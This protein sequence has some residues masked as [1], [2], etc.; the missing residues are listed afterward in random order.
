MG[1]C[2]SPGGRKGLTTRPGGKLLATTL[3]LVVMMLPAQANA[4][5][6]AIGAYIPGASTN[7]GKIDAYARVVG[8][9]P[10]IVNMFKSWPIAPFYGPQ[11]SA[12]A[13]RGAVPLVTWQPAASGARDAADAYPLPQIAAGYYDDYL[14][15]SA[16][17][18]AEW[19]G[20]I[21]V[22]FAPEMN[23]DF[24]P[25]G[26]GANGNTPSDFIGAWRRV[27]TVFR[28]AGADNVEWV[29]APNNGPLGHFRSLYPGDQWVDWLGLSAFNHGGSWGWESFTTTVRAAYR[30]LVR[31]SAKPIILAEAGSGEVGGSKADWITQA[32]DRQLP[33]FR[34]IRALVWFD[35]ADRGADYR[36][37]SSRAS[38]RAFRRATRSRRYRTT[39]AQFLGIPSLLR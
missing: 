13:R 17:A 5:R 33:R 30:D 36:V 21:L 38:S 35:D 22:R 37:N 9:R 15:A 6:V 1:A 31:L 4:A 7:P 20:P 10:V 28:E 19:G 24:Y 12:I 18:A 11:L 23:G 14:R 32:F 26:L 8:H 16:E 39:A 29:W 3:L 34:R 25:W 27:V 2:A